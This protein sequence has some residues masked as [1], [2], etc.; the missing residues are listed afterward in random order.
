MHGYFQKYSF[1]ELQHKFQNTVKTNRI[2]YQKTRINSFYKGTRSHLPNTYKYTYISQNT[3][4]NYLIG[5]HLTGFE[6]WLQTFVK[7]SKIPNWLPGNE[8]T[9]KIIWFWWWQIHKSETVKTGQTLFLNV[10]KYKNHYQFSNIMNALFIS[11]YN[12]HTWFIHI[13]SYHKSN[14]NLI[15]RIS[16]YK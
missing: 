5:V 8:S 2:I 13:F 15:W 16:N 4:L 7:Y 1:K 14:I 6:I 10:Y 9:Y 3:R 11:I 12:S